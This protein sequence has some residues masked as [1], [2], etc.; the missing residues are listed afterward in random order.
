MKPILLA[1]ILLLTACGEKVTNKPEAGAV[2]QVP[3]FEWHVV[4]QKELDT[5]YKQSGMALES[6]QK[7]YGFT[8]VTKD[9]RRVV[10]TTEPQ[11]VDDAVALTLGHEVMHI[12]MG[13]YHK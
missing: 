11:Y 4:D 9:G 7:L 6:K 8:G 1:L 3:A 12:V 2:L 13:S 10:Y 5:V